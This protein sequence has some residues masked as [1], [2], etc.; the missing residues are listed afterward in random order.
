MTFL[1]CAR[2]CCVSVTR[3]PQ[4]CAYHVIRKCEFIGE[5]MGYE[6]IRANA[7]D[8]LCTEMTVTGEVRKA[9]EVTGVARDQE[10]YSSPQSLEMSEEEQSPR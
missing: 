7:K 9:G 8:R 10:T 6:N 2:L 3:V 1:G 4:R 5:G